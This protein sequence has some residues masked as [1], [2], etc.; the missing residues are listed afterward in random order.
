[1]GQGQLGRKEGHEKD[2][3]G[4][5]FVSLP[6]YPLLHPVYKT[7]ALFSAASLCHLNRREYF[8]RAIPSISFIGESIPFAKT[9]KRQ[10]TVTQTEKEGLPSRTS[11]VP[12]SPLSER[13]ELLLMIQ[14][15]LI[16]FMLTTKRISQ[17]LKVCISRFKD[18]IMTCLKYNKESRTWTWSRSSTQE[19]K[20]KTPQ[21]RKCEPLCRRGSH[22]VL[23]KVR[24]VPVWKRLTDISYYNS[25]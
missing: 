9:N 24:Y 25:D 12:A 4:V 13:W 5:R 6:P 19:K 7:H 8:Q 20:L 3:R 17:Q 22:Q 1:M 14:I 18:K 15:V 21:N 23:D 16:K 11:S 2:K 10:A